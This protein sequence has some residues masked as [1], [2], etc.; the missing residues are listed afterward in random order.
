MLRSEKFDSWVLA[1]GGVFTRRKALDL[2][3]TPS[4][5]RVGVRRGEWVRFVGLWRLADHPVTFRSQ[6]CAALLR[7]GPGARITAHPVLASLGLELSDPKVVICVPASRKCAL[8]FARILRDEKADKE[9][10][11]VGGLPSVSRSRAVVDAIRISTRIEAEDI[12]HEALRMGWTSPQLLDHACR[13]LF[14]HKGLT[15]L[16]DLAQ[17]AKSGS[18]AESERRLQILMRAH[19]LRGWKFNSEIKDETGTLLGIGD[20]VLPACRLVVEVDGHAW[21]SSVGRFQRDRTRQ[22]AMVN[23]GWTVLRFTWDDITHRPQYVVR[24]IQMAVDLSARRI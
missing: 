9:L 22:N 14:A 2:G 19:G 7:G 10:C 13:E 23:E 8:P 4:R 12:L 20:A 5:F 1:H 11:M 24:Q 17:Y 15:Q 21:H 3:L 18:H 16:R 6:I